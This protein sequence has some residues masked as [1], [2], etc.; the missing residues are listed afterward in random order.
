[1]IMSNLEWNGIDFIEKPPESL[2]MEVMTKFGLELTKKEA[3]KLRPTYPMRGLVDTRVQTNSA[4]PELLDKL[5]LPPEKM[6]MT[7]IMDIMGAVLVDIKRDGRVAH[8]ILYICSNERVRVL[9]RTT[10]RQLD[11]IQDNFANPDEGE[12]YQNLE[13]ANTEEGESFMDPQEGSTSPNPEEAS[14]EKGEVHLDP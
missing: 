13:E 3:N 11:M 4:G 1:M 14:P 9:S 7:D 5:R 12:V 10:L 8:C 2:P 6:L